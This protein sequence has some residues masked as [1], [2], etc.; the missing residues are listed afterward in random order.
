[1]FANI[2]LAEV[3]ATIFYTLLGFGLFLGCYIIIDRLSG[4]SLR[5]ELIDEHNMAVAIVIGALL[6]ALAILI[7]AVIQ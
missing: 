2:Q 7:A 1:M 5:R 6:I 4:F 3:L